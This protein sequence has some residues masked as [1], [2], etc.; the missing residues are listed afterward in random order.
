HPGPLR[1]E[2]GR[3]HPV[4]PKTAGSS[5]RAYCR[6]SLSAGHPAPRTPK[7][8]RCK[9]GADLRSRRTYKVRHFGLVSARMG[10]PHEL[11]PPVGQGSLS[12]H[13]RV[14]E[15]EIAETGKIGKDEHG[16]ALAREIVVLPDLVGRLLAIVD[17]GLDRGRQPVSQDGSTTVR[18]PS[19]SAIRR[20][21]VVGILQT[22][23]ELL[24]EFI[25]GR[26]GRLVALLPELHQEAPLRFKIFQ[27]RNPAPFRVVGYRGDVFE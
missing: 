1:I 19:L 8:P 6:A 20:I 18:G 25:D 13:R 16:A 12:G 17:V 2:P 3:S 10:L 4:R 23:I 21:P 9:R 14:D 24:L 27:A 5:I 22:P 7:G 11:L 15:L 26:A